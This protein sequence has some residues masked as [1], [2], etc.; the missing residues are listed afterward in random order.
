[1]K[2]TE[3]KTE[4]TEVEVVNTDALEQVELENVDGG[5]S[6]WGLIPFFSAEMTG[7]SCN[8]FYR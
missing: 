7:H 4:V 8:P 5:I 3:N 1:M 6:G 2:N